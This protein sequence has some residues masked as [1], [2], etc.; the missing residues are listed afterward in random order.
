[1]I[2]PIETPIIEAGILIKDAHVTIIP[3]KTVEI[4]YLTVRNKVRNGTTKSPSL[5]INVAVHKIETDFV[6]PV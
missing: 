6:N 1:M 2:G 3:L 4:S 5:F